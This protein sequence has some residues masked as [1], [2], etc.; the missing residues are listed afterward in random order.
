MD[1]IQVLLFVMLSVIAFAASVHAFRTH[2]TYGFFR[3]LAFETLVLLIVS[4]VPRW[5]DDPFSPPQITSW[6]LLGASAA[7]AT[8]GIYLLRAGGKAQGR[9]IEDTQRVVEVGAYRYIRHPMYASLMLFGWGVFFKRIELSTGA[10][11]SLAMAFLVMT[12]RY[13]ERFNLDRFGEAYFEYMKRTK[14]FVPF[15]L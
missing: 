3:F 4:N 11:V 14:M 10:L 5:F 15:L 12:A 6:V 1:P 13:E 2:Q 9:I 8:H 7:L